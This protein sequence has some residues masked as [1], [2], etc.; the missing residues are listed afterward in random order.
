MSLPRFTDI[1]VPGGFPR[2]TY[3]SRDEFKLEA[4][5]TEVT[6]NLCKLAIMT[7]HTKLGKTVLARKILPQGQAVW[8]EGGVVS[9]E[10]DFWHTI[11]G[12]LRA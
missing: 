3:N 11:I 5:L 12:Q 9:E 8:V 4:K 6:E 10:D 7:G 2:Y 1:F